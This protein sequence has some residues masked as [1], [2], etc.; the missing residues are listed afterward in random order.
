MGIFLNTLREGVAIEELIKFYGVDY[1]NSYF[2]GSHN[3]AELDLLLTYK[4]KMLGFEFKLTD[5]PKLTPSMRIAVEDLGLDEL[6]V[7]YP[8][9]KTYKIGQNITVRPLIDFTTTG[10]AK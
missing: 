4:N 6:T 8:G 10:T 3:K 9:T 5:A 2:W 7:I 1:E